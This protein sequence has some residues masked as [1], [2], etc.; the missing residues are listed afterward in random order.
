LGSIEPIL[1]S[2]FYK[3]LDAKSNLI[4]LADHYGQ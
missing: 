4:L 2:L 1:L 3:V